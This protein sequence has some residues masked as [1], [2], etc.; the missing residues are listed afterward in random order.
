MEVME[1]R[2]GSV[3]HHPPQIPRDL[4]WDRSQ[5]DALRCRGFTSETTA[6]PSK[7]SNVC[8]PET[9]LL[10]WNINVLQLRTIINRLQRE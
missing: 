10:K 2:P 7:R 5:A 6:R 1:E 8:V 4:V 9:T 3:P